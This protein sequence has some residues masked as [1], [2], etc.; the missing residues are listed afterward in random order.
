MSSS[1]CGGVTGT[2]KGYGYMISD[3][4][5][6]VLASEHFDSAGGQALWST[7]PGTGTQGYARVRTRYNNGTVLSCNPLPVTSSSGSGGC[8]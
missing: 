1:K 3:S 5:L 4:S 6:A 2:Q 8:S 7:A